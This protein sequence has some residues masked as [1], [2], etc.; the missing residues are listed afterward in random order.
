[1]EEAKELWN[2]NSAK[3]EAVFH[4]PSGAGPT[5]LIIIFLISYL[6]TIY[7]KSGCHLH[8]Y[9]RWGPRDRREV[10]GHSDGLAEDSGEGEE[11]RA[12]G[13]MRHDLGKCKGKILETPPQHT[14]QKN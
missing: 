6:F 5:L 11:V 8:G 12:R 1:M 14:P 13:K 4:G 2:L 7:A 9:Q 3:L 10:G